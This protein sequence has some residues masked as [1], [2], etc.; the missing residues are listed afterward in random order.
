MFH[1][2]LSLIRRFTLE[3]LPLLAAASRLSPKLALSG[4]PDHEYP[5]AEKRTFAFSLP[6]PPRTSL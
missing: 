5:H 4:A 6:S 2:W 1:A 3:Y